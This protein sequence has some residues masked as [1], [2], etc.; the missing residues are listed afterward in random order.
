[1]ALILKRSQ[2]DGLDL[3]PHGLEVGGRAESTFI[4]PTLAKSPDSAISSAL[5]NASRE[6]HVLHSSRSPVPRGLTEGLPRVSWAWT[7]FRAENA[8]AGHVAERK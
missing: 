5:L 7:G 3:A 2:P 1:M 6:G 8:M 4:K